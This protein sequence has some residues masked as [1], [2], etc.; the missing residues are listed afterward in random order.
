MTVDSQPRKRR[1]SSR[2]AALLRWIH[3]Y[4]SMLGFAALM[5][6]GF[7]GLT[8]NH[9]TWFGASEV[10]ITDEQGELPEALLANSE[11]AEQTID[12]LG[13]AEWLRAEHHLSGRVTEFSADEFE[14]FVVFKG[15]AYSVDVFVDRT[16]R[17]Y[18]LTESRAGIVAALN[19]LHRGRDSGEGWAWL[20]DVSAIVTLLMSVSGFA[21]IFYIRRR[22]TTGLLAALAGTIA[23]VVVWFAFV[24]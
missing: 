19:D 21:L 7:T 6:F 16:S 23:L 24:P 15:P 17:K 14:L 8:L 1:W 9:P 3:I 12:K 4:I 5:F 22:R 11:G 20:I 13:I 2:F 10:V 18:T